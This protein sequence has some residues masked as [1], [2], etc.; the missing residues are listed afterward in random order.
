MFSFMS[1]LFSILGSAADLEPGASLSAKK[2]AILVHLANLRK[3]SFV[4][5]NRL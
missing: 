2:R 1:R 3:V 5:P 4:F